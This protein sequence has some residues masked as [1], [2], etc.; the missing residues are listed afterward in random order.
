MI[1]R[2]TR[3]LAERSGWQVLERRFYSPV[4]DL[5]ELPA[6]AFDRR[7]P[8]LGIDL[9]PARQVAFAENELAPYLAEFATGPE[10]FP[11]RNDYYE[12]GDAEIAY[13]FVRHLR[14]RRIVEL[15]SGFSTLVLAHA[16]QR[17]RADGAPCRLGSFDP[18]PPPV[19]ADGAPAQEVPDEEFAAL[20]GGDLLFVDTSHTVKLAG[21]VNRIVLD[22]LPALA[23]G[24]WVHFHDIWLP[25]E[26]H[27]TLVREMEMYWNEQYLLQAFLVENPSWEVVFATRAVA[28]AEAERLRALIPEYDGSNFPSSFWIRRK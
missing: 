22:V 25:Y 7:S 4:P 23:P 21:D 8:M 10:G 28:V 6:D 5:D 24:V 12:T 1:R 18:Y 26:Y 2:L 16:A 9:D 11:I 17:N 20:E 3:R 14:P 15:G 19:L 13:A 27:P